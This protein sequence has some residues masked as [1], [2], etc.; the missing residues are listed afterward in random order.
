MTNDYTVTC[1]GCGKE[2]PI[3]WDDEECEEIPIDW[4]TEG[5]TAK[6]ER[7]ELIEHADCADCDIMI[8]LYAERTRT[9]IRPA[10]PDEV[11]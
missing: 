8:L 3:V 11:E 7:H 4:P 5:Y 10:D 9:T 2:L 6:L 1:P